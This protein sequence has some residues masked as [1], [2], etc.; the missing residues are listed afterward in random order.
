MATTQHD[1]RTTDTDLP[2]ERT[3]MDTARDVVGNVTTAANDAMAKLPDAATTTRD[4][5]AEAN[6]TITASSDDTLSAGTLVSV[7][8][9]LGL[10]VGGANRFLVLLALLP[11]AAMGLTLLD[12]QSTSGPRTDK[13]SGTTSAR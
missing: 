4:A 10:L 1:T 6:R 9:A 8:F 2:D 12:R 7:G 5:L 3:P 13:A 11:A